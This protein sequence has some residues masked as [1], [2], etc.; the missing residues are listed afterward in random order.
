MDALSIADSTTPEPLAE[1]T[2]DIAGA[3]A[4]RIFMLLDIKTNTE[5]E[6]AKIL[7]AHL[8]EVG[9]AAWLEWCAANWG[10]KRAAAYSHL[11]PEQMQKKRDQA[12]ASRAQ[13]LHGVDVEPDIEPDLELGI[14]ADRF[15]MADR[16][17]VALL[18]AGV[19]AKRVEDRGVDV[20]WRCRCLLG[21]VRNQT[22][23]FTS[24]ELEELASLLQEDLQRRIEERREEEGSGQTLEPTVA[25]TDDE[26][27]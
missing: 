19:I 16:S 10:W 9:E 11:N 20:Q 13:R 25:T 26:Q 18:P 21:Y 12:K 23:D 4:S 14:V 24:A 8:D 6:I 22:D 17:E 1:A 15:E 2:T 3:R 27:E 5:T 7:R